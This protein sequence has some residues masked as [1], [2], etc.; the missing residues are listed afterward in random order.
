MT[1]IFSTLIKTAGRFADAIQY[2]V[3]DLVPESLIFAVE[4]QSRRRF[5]D[6]SILEPLR[7]LLASYNQET[8]L[9]L[10]GGLAAKWDISR[11]LTNVLRLE[12]EEE[13][14]PHILQHHIEAPIFITGLP[15]SGTTF[16]H[17]LLA[18]DETNRVPI[19]WQTIYPYPL[20]QDKR[21]DGR[22]ARVQNQ[23]RMFELLSPGV[24][25]LHPLAACAPQECTEITAHVFQSLRFDTTHSVPSYQQWLI[26]TGHTD[27]FRFHRRFLQHL[28]HQG[29]QGQWILKCPDH[30]FTLD[31]ITQIYP[32]AR[33]VFVHRDPLSVLPSVAKLTEILRAPFTRAL[34]R[35]QIGR[36]VSE[37]W[38]E[39]ASLIS[40]HSTTTDKI[41]H[42]HF[43]SLTSEPVKTIA[44]LY[45]HFGLRF[46]TFAQQRI[47]AFV[48]N[49]PRGGY[50]VNRYSLRE[51]GLDADVLYEGFWPYMRTFGIEREVKSHLDAS[52]PLAL[53]TT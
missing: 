8:N 47:E 20:E 46:S 14:A 38:L 44:S 32:D 6:L 3:A 7:I 52:A 23:L 43:R 1:S 27:A 40:D 33:F 5:R 37:R 9:S 22:I 15:R 29:G 4:R 11:L 36:Q 17:S 28:Q 45:D 30:V 12:A 26:K 13:R 16:L 18:K 35:Y 25:S 2:R 51:F 41:F 19:L 49:T 48:R 50:G 42:V 24:G 34:D 21:S 53:A 31:A 10:F 39:G